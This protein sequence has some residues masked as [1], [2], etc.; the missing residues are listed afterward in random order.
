MIQYIV[1]Q[2]TLRLQCSSGDWRCH[3][4]SSEGEPPAIECILH[5]AP[6]IQC[7]ASLG[8]EG[9]SRDPPTRLSLRDVS[10]LGRQSAP[11]PTPPPTAIAFLP[12]P[13]PQFIARMAD[14]GLTKTRQTGVMQ[15]P[16]FIS[17]LNLLYDATNT[18]V[19]PFTPDRDAVVQ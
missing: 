17:A 10:L 4:D 15:M 19:G 13:L 16:N 14:H 1:S 5:H 2:L 6:P 9:H 8:R 7:K 18:P 3:Y 12:C 11:P